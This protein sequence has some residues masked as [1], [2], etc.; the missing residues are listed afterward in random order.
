MK[1]VFKI[2]GGGFILVILALAA[3]LI[4]AHMQVRGV[5]PA[6]PSHAEL[7][8]L[9]GSLEKPIS[10]S[11]ILT[12]FQELERGQI[13]HISILVEWRNGKRFLID[14]GMSE[15][16]AKDFGMLLKKMDSSARTETILGTAPN[17]LGPRVKDIAGV[18][19]T[20]LHIDHVEGINE[21]CQARG[22]GAVVLQTP[23][24]NTL[25]NFNTS[26][27]SELV[28]NSC[29]QSADFQRTGNSNL[30]SSEQF[31][32][33]AA[34]ELGGHTPG[35]TLWAVALGNKVLLFSGDTTNDKLSIDHDIPKQLVYSYF[36]VPENTN[37]TATLRKWLRKLDQ[38]AS[39]SVIVSHDLA[40]T[41]AHLPAYSVD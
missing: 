10:L 13:S 5:E 40:N 27:S 23:S 26:E 20:H 29:L 7:L 28:A 11:Y 8:A 22:Q 36:L 38:S 1:W 9:T 30:Y 34:F 31:P 41:K 2:I 15:Q 4:P 37:R 6:L 35:S 17:I 18:G 21:F 24:Q 12:S 39:F 19:F 14:T 3:I 16:G 32:G 25:H 33:M